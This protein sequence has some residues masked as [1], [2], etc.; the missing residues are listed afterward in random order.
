M[1][2][3]I[4]RATKSVTIIA[5]M[6]LFALGTYNAMFMS[7]LDFMSDSEIKFAKRLDEMNGRIVAAKAPY[8]NWTSL[9]NVNK[10]KKKPVIVAPKIVKKKVFKK[11]VKKVAA[12]ISNKP[13]PVVA[14][15]AI[16]KSLD[17]QLVE[18][19]NVKRYKKPLT[20]GDFTGELYSANGIIETLSVQLP[21]NEEIDI[22]FAEMAGN[23]FNYE[24]DG[25]KFSGMMYEVSSGTYMV[26]LTNG[27]FS[28]TRMK[29]MND[30]VQI[31]NTFANNNGYAQ[32]NY[33]QEV[34]AQNNQDAQL[35]QQGLQ[36]NAQ[37]AEK[38]FIGNQG[39]NFDQRNEI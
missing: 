13:A 12:K 4:I 9:V 34:A 6:M 5:S 39:F 1:K 36:A 32:D 11:K 28:G 19:Y 8:T 21:N 25:N 17:L 31:N 30:N 26:T 38:P 24:M 7:S 23:V 15:P 27:P 37:G 35:Q 10:P 33:D 18:L 3:L 16:K 14:Q 22:S 2:K 20:S 29:F